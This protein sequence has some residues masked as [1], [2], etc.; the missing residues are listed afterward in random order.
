[1]YFVPFY[2]ST[3]AEPQQRQGVKGVAGRCWRHPITNFLKNWWKVFVIVL[4][5]LIFAPLPILWT[6]KVQ[7]CMHVV[8]LTPLYTPGTLVRFLL[9]IFRLPAAK[10]AYAITIVAVYWVTEVVP[11]AAT[12]LLPL[13]LFPALGVLSAEQ[14]TSGT[15]TCCLWMGLWWPWPLRNGIIC[16]CTSE[17]H[18]LC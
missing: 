16:T 14:T 1:M 11:I 7:T 13:I 17:W 10:A 5:P 4:T 2:T 6:V 3:I 9:C 12:A 8:V 15:T 18:C